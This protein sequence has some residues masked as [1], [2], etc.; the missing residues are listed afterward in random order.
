MKTKITSVEVICI[1]FRQKKSKLKYLPGKSN[2][3]L[4]SL[5]GES[6]CNISS[7]LEV[8]IELLDLVM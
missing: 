5:V 7:C 1:R 8:S 4:S 3:N 6:V 2:A